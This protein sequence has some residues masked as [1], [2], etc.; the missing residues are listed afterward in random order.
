MTVT[1]HGPEVSPQTSMHEIASKCTSSATTD[2]FLQLNLPKITATIY[3]AVSG[4]FLLLSRKTLLKKVLFF[5]LESD[6][7]SI[8]S[9]YLTSS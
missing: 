5:F 1:Q 3:L 9:H 2:F 7:F 6:E 8:R 4:L